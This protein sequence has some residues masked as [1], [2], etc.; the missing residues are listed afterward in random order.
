MSPSQEPIEDILREGEFRALLE[1]APVAVIIVDDH[2]HIA[3]ANAR[4]RQ[5][6]GYEQD[7]LAGQ[8]IE[9]LIPQRFEQVHVQ[10]R[11][12]YMA[13]PCPRPMGTH[14]ELAARRKDGSEFPVEVGLNAIATQ[15]GVMVI[16]Y[17]V[18]ITERRR[19]EEQLRLQSTAL[20]AAANAIMITDRQGRIT[21]ANPA[22]TRIT[23]YRL[24]QAVGHNTRLLKSNQQDTAVYKELWEKV[25]AGQVWRGELINRRQDGST[26]VEEQTITPVRDERGRITHFIAIKQDITARKQAEERQAQ[27]LKELENANQE[28]KDFAYIVSHDL[29]APLRAI[30]SLAEWLAQDYREQ[31]GSEGQEMVSLLMARVKRMHDLIEGVLQYSRVGRA[32]EEKVSVDLNQLLAEVIDS[33]APPPHITVSVETEL[34]TLVCEKTRLGQIFQNLLGNAVKYMDKPQG[35]V[36]VS[37]LELEQAWQFSVADNGPGIEEKYFDKI[38]QLFQTLQ[39]RDQVEST[40]VGLTVVKKAIEL[41][42]GRVWVESKLGQGSTFFFTLPK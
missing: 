36:R 40:G 14:L 25:L 30:S 6:F 34:P 37:S 1:Y 27:L 12:C 2:G 7:E 35:E 5:E 19:A 8:P 10:H 42:G 3:L 24:D 11:R 13:E 15:S 32:R 21:W 16:S 28:L 17:L 26:Y 22:F 41:Y 20:E 18:D 29:K 39:P 23:G 33:L 38:F 9:M 31:L 4:A